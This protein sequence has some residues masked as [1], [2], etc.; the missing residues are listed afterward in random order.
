MIGSVWDLRRCVMCVPT[1]EGVTIAVRRDYNAWQYAL[2]CAPGVSMGNSN[3]KNGKSNP[4]IEAFCQAEATHE[5]RGAGYC[6][7]H[8]R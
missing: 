7:T 5:G 4:S 1:G 8:L 3:S 2:V 6:S